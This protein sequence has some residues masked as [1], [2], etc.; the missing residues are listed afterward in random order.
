MNEGSSELKQNAKVDGA[1]WGRN[2]LRRLSK[3][4]GIDPRLV[5]SLVEP[6][7][8]PSCSSLQS[9]IQ[10]I[11]DTC[12][13]LT[14]K[15]SVNETKCH[16]LANKQI[17]FT[18]PTDTPLSPES[19][20]LLSESLEDQTNRIW[21]ENRLRRRESERKLIYPRGESLTY[22]VNAEAIIH[23]NQVAFNSNRALFVPVIA[24]QIRARFLHIREVNARFKRL[25]DHWNALHRIDDDASAGNRGWKEDLE[26]KRDKRSQP[27]RSMARVTRSQTSI[28]V[29][30]ESATPRDPAYFRSRQA[31][32]SLCYQEPVRYVYV[33]HNNKL[34]TDGKPMRC[35]DVPRTIPCEKD[36]NCPLKLFELSKRSRPWSDMEKFIFINGFFNRPKDFRYIANTLTNR[37]VQDVIDFYYLHKRGM[38]VKLLLRIQ[39]LMWKNMHYDVRPL[40]LVAAYGIGLPIPEEMLG[41]NYA[42]Y[43]IADYIKEDHMTLLNS[44]QGVKVEDEVLLRHPT[45]QYRVEDNAT[46]TPALLTERRQVRE[47]RIEQLLM[48]M[49]VDLKNCIPSEEKVAEGHGEAVGSAVTE[50]YHRRYSE[51]EEDEFAKRRS[52]SF[53]GKRARADSLSYSEM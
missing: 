36:C 47:K 17:V 2:L 21:E 26:N 31:D 42:D 45:Y 53:S 6:I 14:H 7:P 16:A 19:T 28:M 44:Q 1:I 25:N 29:E 46:I 18:L 12:D 13:Q 50:P 38:Y 8:V 33:N 32:V 11:N 22:R 5:E 43:N 20:S 27:P 52:D 35:Q 3:R 9:Y 41:P 51:I 24:R 48:N 4:A 30:A 10:H 34:T 37:S 49:G 23:R 39:L 15:I 40:I